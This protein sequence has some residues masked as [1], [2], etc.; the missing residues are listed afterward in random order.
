VWYRA[1]Q[2]GHRAK[3]SSVGTGS[4]SASTMSGR[5]DMGSEVVGTCQIDWTWGQIMLDTVQ[6]SAGTG[7]GSVD[8]GPGSIQYRYKVGLC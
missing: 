8:T 2:Y 5:S 6:R 7:P 4:G 3:Y 1:R